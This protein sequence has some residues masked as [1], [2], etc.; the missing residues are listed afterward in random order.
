MNFC[1]SEPAHKLQILNVVMSVGLT[2]ALRST[3]G[4]LDVDRMLNL[5]E[6]RPKRF[7]NIN[8]G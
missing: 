6:K 8:S 7:N 4:A 3:V 5:E 1:C 2:F